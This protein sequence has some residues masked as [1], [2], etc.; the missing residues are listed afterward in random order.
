[1]RLAIYCD[2]SY[3]RDDGTLWAELAFAR[4]VAGLAPHFEHITLVGR[5]HP[6]RGRWHHE[7]PSDLDF[8]PLPYYPSL[9][10]GA[11]PARALFASLPLFWRLL[12]RVDAVWL[13]GPHPMAVAFAALAALRRRPVALGIRQDLAAYIRNRHPRARTLGIAAAVLEAAFRLIARRAAVVVVGSDLA[14][15][16]RRARR[17][18]PITISLV[19][20]REIAA[21]DASRA[22]RWDGELQVLSVGRLDAEKNP[23]LLADVLGR[24]LARRPRWRLVVCGDGPLK[25]ELDARLRE[26]GIREHADLVGYIPVEAGLVDVYRAS[27]VLLHCSWTEGV[28]QVLYEAFAQR[29]PVVATDVGGV[30]DAADG[31]ALVVPPGDAEAA[32]VAVERLADDGA[33]RDRLAAAGADRAREHSLEAETE[34]VARFLSE[35]GGGGAA[36][37]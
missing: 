12:G 26:L 25:D 15:R 13:L 11:A 17:L 8:E 32:A 9:A 6:E 23:L 21:A 10:R 19:S 4:F 34:R 33:L 29:L 27:H 14:R 31:A 5:L 16:Y 24:L 28:P 36:I 30:R 1:M 2:F 18:L 37:R 3:R 22:R 7:I 20:E 35:M